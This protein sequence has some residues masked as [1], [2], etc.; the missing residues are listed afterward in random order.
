MKEYIVYNTT[1]I[2]LRTGSVSDDDF[3]KQAQEGESV[4]EG[5]AND[6][7]Q[8]IVGGKIVNK[9]PEELEQNK[10]KIKKIPVEN[11]PAEITK[12]QLQSI[13]DRLAFLE[14]R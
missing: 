5:S 7:T 8:K 1:G 6:A 13:L 2:I 3:A 9:T 14:S 11:Q 10:P 12:G 4:I